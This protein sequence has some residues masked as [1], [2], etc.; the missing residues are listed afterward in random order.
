MPR[1]RAT[2]VV[3]TTEQLVARARAGEAEAFDQLVRRYQG[4]AFPYALATVRDV[5]LAEDATQQAMIA[6][7][8]NLASLREPSRFGG[9]LRGIVRFECL[10]MLRDRAGWRIDPLELEGAVERIDPAVDLERQAEIAIEVQRVLGLMA[11]LPD[12]QRVVAQ[13]YYLGDQSQAAVAEFLGLSVSAVNNRLREAR[14][15]LRQEGTSIMRSASIPTPDFAEIVGKV[16]RANGTMIDTRL[17]RAARPAL[18]TAVEV[19]G[20]DRALAAF[21][22]QYLDD[23]TARLI[24]VTGSAEAASVAHGMPV[25][26]RGQTTDAQLSTE[27][28]DRLVQ[29]HRLNQTGEKIATGIKAIDLFAPLVEGGVIAIVGAMNVGK[30]VVVEELVTRLTHAGRTA[31]ILVF[32]KSPDELGLVHQLDYRIDG[33]VAVVVIPVEEASPDALAAG[34][35]RVDTVLA[36]SLDLGQARMYPAIDPVRSRAVSAS[37]DPVAERARAVLRDGVDDVRIELVRAYLTQPFFVA[38]PYT[39]RPGVKVEPEVAATDLERL[40]D[41]DITDLSPEGLKMGGSLAH[42]G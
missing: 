7:Y 25:R 36:M 20:D 24:T 21:V 4:M 30:L 33:M 26:S 5:Q 27:I 35:E 2:A 16:I 29:T 6:G 8:C 19:G 13:L 9:W 15:I 10:R 11:A 12:R 22:S 41:G 38:E 31:T 18:L 14:V 34:L 3:T 1:A 17:D 42:I 40:L 23:D 39:G 37:T 28:I 32:L